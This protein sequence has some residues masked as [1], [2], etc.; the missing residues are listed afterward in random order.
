MK[1]VAVTINR[2][3][4]LKVLAGV[5]AA[6]ALTGAATLPARAGTADGPP[7]AF[8]D[9]SVATF[10]VDPGRNRP[11]DEPSLT[12][13]A[14]PLAW[15]DAMTLAERRWLIGE[16][17]T[18]ASYG[19]AV[20]VLE[21]SGDWSYV[22]VVG[23]P[24]PRN[25]LGYPGWVP[26]V[27]LTSNETFRRLQARRP[28]ATV[29]AE[30]APLFANGGLTEQVMELSFNT[31]LPVLGVSR[32]AVRVAVPTGGHRW[33]RRGDVAIYRTVDDI[34]DPTPSD[35]EATAMRFLGLRYLW[36]GV[37]AYGFD[38][39]GFTSTVYSA[40]GI[41]IP[42]DA[43]P[44][45][46][47]GSKVDDGPKPNHANLQTGDLIFFARPGGSIHHVGMYADGDII[48]APTNSDTEESPLERV[49]LEDHRYI[50][51]Y[52]GAVRYL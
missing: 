4:V 44:Q 37:S 8:V 33:L 52:V 39:S 22:A 24:T 46:D 11:V 23:Q 29:T 21:T 32:R 26:T 16:L 27:Q 9:V 25:E 34:P 20:R 2:R 3:N 51:E 38:C 36:A 35:L 45:H 41:T 13:P 43:G 12:N 40:N 48:D 42:R 6:T 47:A 17:E 1:I 14:D 49:R 50:S 10:W 18:Q 30:L 7:T 15:M 19:N 31:R 28:F 5:P